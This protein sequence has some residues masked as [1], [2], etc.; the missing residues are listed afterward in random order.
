MRTYCHYPLY[1]CNKNHC[2]GFI[3]IKSFLFYSKKINDEVEIIEKV[4]RSELL[5]N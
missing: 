4:I 5:K 3:V 2:K 1:L